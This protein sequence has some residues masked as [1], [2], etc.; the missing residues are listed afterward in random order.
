MKENECENRCYV[1]EG[2]PSIIN[3]VDHIYYNK[4]EIKVEGEEE[5]TEEQDQQQEEI[6]NQENE[7]NEESLEH[8][9]KQQKQDHPK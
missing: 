6:K 3:E 2:L 7:I 1:V 9:E 8:N 4:V 5:E